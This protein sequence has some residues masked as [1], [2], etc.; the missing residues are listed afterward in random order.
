MSTAPAAKAR[1]VSLLEGWPALTG[2]QVAYSGPVKEAETAA[3]MV[4]LG[5]VEGDQEWSSLGA[6]SRQ[7]EYAINL[8]C[9]VFRAQA[10]G[11]EQQAEERCWTIWNEVCNALVSDPGLTGTFRGG[12]AKPGRFTQVTVPTLEPVGF[13]ARMDAQ[14][15]VTAQLRRT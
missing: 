12:W 4:F 9:I 14:V 8:F 13:S 15:D 2:V 5:G 11:T 3:E 1:I 10:E 6:M 7:E